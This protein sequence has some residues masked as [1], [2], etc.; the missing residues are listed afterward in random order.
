[1]T[2]L[3]LPTA[4]PH[5][6]PFLVSD[7]AKYPMRPEFFLAGHTRQYLVTSWSKPMLN[8]SSSLLI[9]NF[10]DEGWQNPFYFG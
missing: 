1:M 8:L 4:G 9:R 10:L 2:H 3:G 5:K 6:I 7:F